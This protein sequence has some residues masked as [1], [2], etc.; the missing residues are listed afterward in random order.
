VPART[1]EYLVHHSEAVQ[2]AIGQ[3]EE[4]LEPVRR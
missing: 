1:L 3:R 2:I 4:D